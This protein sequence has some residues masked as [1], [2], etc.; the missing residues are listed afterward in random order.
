M[1]P[2]K[3]DFGWAMT[4]G[5][6]LISVSK[7]MQL[8]MAN[9]ARPFQPVPAYPSCVLVRHVARL[10]TANPVPLWRGGTGRLAD[11]CDVSSHISRAP[12]L[13]IMSQEELWWLPESFRTRLTYSAL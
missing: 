8:W 11:V 9:A 1:K 10:R 2:E 5:L 4:T 3:T 12:E 7:L 6:R 13:A